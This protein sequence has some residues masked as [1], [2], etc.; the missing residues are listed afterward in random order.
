MI[1]NMIVIECPH[2][3]EDI[4]MDDDAHNG[5]KIHNSIR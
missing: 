4:E 1:G 2:C 3:D 5:L